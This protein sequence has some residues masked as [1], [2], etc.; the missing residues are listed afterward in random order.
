ML[1]HK[2]K[3]VRE[4]E[5]IE[6]ARTLLFDRLV[7]TEPKTYEEKQALNVLNKEALRSSV[8]C[9]LDRL[10]STRRTVNFESE[11]L[12]VID[13]GIPDLS[14]LSPKVVVQQKRIIKYISQAILTFE[15]RLKDVSV[16]IT[17]VSDFDRSIVIR[18]EANLVVGKV[19]EPIYFVKQ[20]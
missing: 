17:S 12:T 16:S 7:N 14:S 3:L 10:L 20:Y 9:E 2:Y 6:G 4:P 11:D 5:I 8:Y 1:H 18:I 19:L 15:P 13:Y